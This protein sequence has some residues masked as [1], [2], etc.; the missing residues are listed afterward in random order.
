L[1]ALSGHAR[2]KKI[3][4]LLS[5]IRDRAWVLEIGCGDGWVEEYLRTRSDI[6][7]HGID[8]EPPADYVGSIKDWRQLGLQGASYDAIIAFEVLEHVD[9]LDD[10]YELLKP[11]GMFLI[12]TPVPHWDWACWILER[13]GINQKRGTPH[14]NLL[15]VNSIKRFEH[16]E[17]FRFKVV[18]QWA[19]L[20]KPV[21]ENQ[22]REFR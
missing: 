7:Y 11:G 18:G 13:I 15:Y 14:T 5:H 3:E 16:I 19:R 6:E 4:L 22:P 2:D 12:T 20:I 21:Q 1:G 17:S 10:C 9:C 8:L